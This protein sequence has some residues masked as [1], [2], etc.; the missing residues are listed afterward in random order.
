MLAE[1]N[2]ISLPI[3]Q[4]SIKD[5]FDFYISKKFSDNTRKAYSN[6]IKQ[7]IKYCFDVDIDFVTIDMLRNLSSK[8]A[9]KF[10]ID[11]VNENKYS[12]VT[13][14]RK[15]GVIK[16][17]LDDM[18]HDIIDNTQETY[19]KVNPLKTYK[20]KVTQNS[21]YGYF[22]HEEMLKL[23]DVAEKENYELSVYI[24]LLYKSSCRAECIRNINK[25]NFYIVGNS[26]RIKVEDKGR[27]IA[28]IEIGKRLY[29]DC[30]DLADEEGRIFK[31]SINYAGR[32]LCGKTE[33]HPSGS[34]KHNYKNTLASK[35]GISEEEAS[36]DGRYLTLHSIKK[37]G[38][39]TVLEK[40]GSVTEA[41]RQGHHATTQYL[42]TYNN[43]NKLNN[44]SRYIDL[45]NNNTNE[46]LKNKL[47]EMSKEDLI[48]LIMSASNNTKNELL[49]K[50]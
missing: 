50:L 10:F 12:Q 49:Q 18:C 24:R 36:K 6:D 20:F 41:S 19:L 3:T 31:F 46:L 30:L 27:K 25:D 45:E 38:V 11:I 17:F 33:Y 39:T 7:W 4:N 47:E 28:D 48:N 14:A 9:Q 13:I 1:S 37:A 42:L 22:T 26:Y 21:S 32:K 8:K 5:Y 34:I 23:I 29:K 16:S 43:S 44:S 40:S 35:I 15:L 2:V